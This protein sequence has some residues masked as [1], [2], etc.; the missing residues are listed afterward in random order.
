VLK[1]YDGRDEVW[2]LILFSFVQRIDVVPSS[3]TLNGKVA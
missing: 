2:I 3:M 1:K